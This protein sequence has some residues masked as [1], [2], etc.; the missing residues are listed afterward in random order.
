ME[1]AQLESEVRRLRGELQRKE[2]A[3]HRVEAQSAT[4]S[5]ELSVALE[6]VRQLRARLEEERKEEEVESS[7]GDADP[8]QDESSN[9]VVGYYKFMYMYTFM[10]ALSHYLCMLRQVRY[11]QYMYVYGQY[12]VCI[13]PIVLSF[14]I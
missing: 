11:I 5:K 1:Q 13:S 14:N 6:E 10:N 9:E 4:R 8:P 12:T 3:L 2:T 7:E